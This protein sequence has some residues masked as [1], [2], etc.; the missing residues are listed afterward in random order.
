[1]R[2][3]GRGAVGGVTKF[4]ISNTNLIGTIGKFGVNLSD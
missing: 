1:M 4:P 3:W 2:G